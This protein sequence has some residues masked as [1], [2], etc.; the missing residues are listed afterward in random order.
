MTTFLSDG[1]LISMQNVLN[2][3]LPGTV[4]IQRKTQTSDGQG[5]RIDAWAAVGTTACRV[6]PFSSQGAMGS[7]GDSGAG[8]RA[9][10]ER[11]ITLPANADVSESDRIVV[12]S[13]TYEV[14][15]MDGP[16][17]MELARRVQAVKV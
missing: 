11:M 4:V 17:S 8:L 3:S 16:R 14:V 1:D 2:R 15:S 6:S 5:G 7:E 10:R 9:Q 12:S 13:T